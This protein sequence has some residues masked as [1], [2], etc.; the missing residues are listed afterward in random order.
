MDR[1]LGIQRGVFLS[2]VLIKQSL[3]ETNEQT[4]GLKR[5]GK[6]VAI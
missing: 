2:A 3:R 6:T 4:T 5:T 1:L